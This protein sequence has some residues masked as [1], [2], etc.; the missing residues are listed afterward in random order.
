M[1]YMRV[2]RC[3][4]YCGAHIHA[5]SIVSDFLCLL[6]LPAQWGIG[7]RRLPCWHFQLRDGPWGKIYWLFTVP[8]LLGFCFHSC[9]PRYIR[10][11]YMLDFGA[12]VLIRRVF[13]LRGAE[14]WKNFKGVLDGDVMKVGKIGL[15]KKAIFYN[16]GKFRKLHINWG[17]LWAGIVLGIIGEPHIGG[18]YGVI[19]KREGNRKSPGIA[20]EE[21]RFSGP[22]PL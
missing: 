4:N 3:W 17:C 5:L 14:F 8:D 21:Y 6:G 22:V 1:N 12:R 7:P 18:R 11:S 9:L 16:R 20:P 19:I 13:S 15:V 2:G 10:I